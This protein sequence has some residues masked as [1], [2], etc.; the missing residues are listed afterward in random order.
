MNIL[1][2]AVRNSGDASQ[3]RRP[4]QPWAHPT[5]TIQNYSCETWEK[6]MVTLK[7]LKGDP[8]VRRVNT[9]VQVDTWSRT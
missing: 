7:M 3:K 5:Q 2:T 6:A 4:G 9:Y 8:A 1:I